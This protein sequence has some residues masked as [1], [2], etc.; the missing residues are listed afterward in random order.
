[1]V[2]LAHEQSGTVR[3][4]VKRDDLIH[5]DVPGNKWRKLARNLPA[6]AAQNHDTLLTFGG[7]FSNHIAATAAAGELFG[8]SSIGVIRGE[9]HQ[10]L[11]PVL[12]GAVERGMRLT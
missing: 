10:P 1:M 3:L 4:V 9:Q 7:A 11:N 8:F 5:P 12:A 6:A 2:E